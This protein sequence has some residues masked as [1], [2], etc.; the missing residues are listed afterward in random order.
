MAS[1]TEDLQ[2]N[3]PQGA[4]ALTEAQ[5]TEM[6]TNIAEGRRPGGPGGHGRPRAE[7]AGSTDR[8][9]SNL[10]LLADALGIDSQTLLEQ[11]R[12]GIDLSSLLSGQT[13]S[14]GYGSS[15]LASLQGGVA[16]DE[17]A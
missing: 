8:A 7:D 4:P 2:A 15:L 1:L 14:T 5:M 12:S 3:A 11:L 6:A 16:V 13:G 10:S 17:T 9:Q